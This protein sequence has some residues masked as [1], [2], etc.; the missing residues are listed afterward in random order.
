M[1]VSHVRLCTLTPAPAHHHEDE[2]SAIVSLPI[3]QPM[4]KSTEVRGLL[5]SFC[6]ACFSG[7]ALSLL[8][9]VTPTFLPNFSLIIETSPCGGSSSL[10]LNKIDSVLLFLVLHHST[11]NIFGPLFQ[12]C[13]K[14]ASTPSKL[15]GDQRAPLISK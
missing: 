7:I 3:R 4:S 9:E 14:Q 5:S 15:C 11:T 10:A 6:S 12:S 1:Y 8:L 2:T 13:T